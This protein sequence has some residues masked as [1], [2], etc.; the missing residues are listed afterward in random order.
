MEASVILPESGKRNILVTSAL[1][2]VNNV[3]HLG[4]IIGSVLSA[5]VF[6]RYCRARGVN[7]LFVGGTDEYGASTEARALKEGCTC[8]ELCDRYHVIH[9][10][11]YSWFQISF[12]IFGRTT[13][14][15]HTEIT[16]K[17]VHKLDENGFLSERKTLQ[18]YCEEPDHNRFLS[19]RF[20]EGECPKCAFP[21]ARG[22]QCDHC[23]RLLDT[24]DLK[25][26]RCKI[27]GM[28]PTRK[29]ASHLYFGLDK[30]QDEVGSFVRKATA[31]SSWSSNSEAITSAALMEGLTAMSITRYLQWGTAVPLPN[32]EGKILYPWFDACIG[33]VSI[34]ANYTDQ[35][36]KW[37]Q[38]PDQVQLY[39]FL[40][41]DNVP[42]HSVVFPATQIGTRENWTTLHYLSATEYLT[43]EGEK[44]SK[45]R[46]VGVFGDS[47]QATGVDP[48]VWRF[49]LLR[50]RPEDGDEDFDWESFAEDHT[51][52]LV[53]N[54][55]GFVSTVME[56]M[57]LLYDGTVPDGSEYD[58]AS[59]G[60]FQDH[61]NELLRRYNEELGHARLR[62]GIGTVL[63][64][65]RLAT[66]Y[67]LRGVDRS[68][69]AAVI[70]IAVNIVWLL[71][72]VVAPYMPSTARR[73][74]QQLGVDSDRLQI[75][76]R[77]NPNSIKPG[78]RI[79]E[80]VRLFNTINPEKV[81]EWR[82]KFGSKCEVDNST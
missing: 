36:K 77:W 42:F 51:E 13:T 8:Q 76:D 71:A 26:P 17:I 6:A 60:Q 22:D 35:W 18:L 20:V 1:P 29:E 59:F 81:C 32:H 52:E 34:T 23:G 19:D 48:D 72:A 3:P 21:D 40:G 50:H 16:H 11:I 61:V 9:A 2:Y 55:G 53:K 25:S 39:Q 37:W 82:R 14:E 45:S 33:Y 41:K 27:D 62:S 57:C 38:N 80:P 78:H 63:A 64:I 70:R 73:I 43:Y 28:T 31:A 10:D 24:L 74:Q 79:G 75:P 46:N 44:F 7:T 5:D 68:S 15:L 65:S 47:A 69:F 54:L 4:N 30:L 67:L 66:E 49:F 58:E 12:D 56:Y